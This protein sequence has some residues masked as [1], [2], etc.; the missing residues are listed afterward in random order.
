MNPLD[1]SYG[2]KWWKEPVDS[3]EEEVEYGRDN[4]LLVT[5]SLLC[6]GVTVAL[7]RRG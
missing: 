7:R 1:L 5:H 3:G 2:C 4:C 6:C